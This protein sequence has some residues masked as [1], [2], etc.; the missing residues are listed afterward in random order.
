MSARR[1]HPVRNRVDPAPV[2]IVID[3]ADL[4]VIA[5]R[6]ATPLRRSEPVAW[7]AHV[8]QAA[9]TKAGFRAAPGRP[10]YLG[11]AAV[12]VSGRR[13]RPS[14]VRDGYGDFDYPFDRLRN[15]EEALSQAGFRSIRI[16]D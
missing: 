12:Y 4:S 16:D 6:I 13:L 3:G 1:A 7:A 2:D 15:I 14:E 10:L 5:V 11:E 9:L 8:V